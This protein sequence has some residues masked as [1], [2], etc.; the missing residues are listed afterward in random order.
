MIEKSIHRLLMHSFSYE[1]GH[2]DINQSKLLYL[3]YMV[4]DG[5]IR[6]LDMSEVNGY[7]PGDLRKAL[8]CPW[9]IKYAMNPAKERGTIRTYTGEI[10]P[11]SEENW[12]PFGK[13]RHRK[14]R[15]CWASPPDA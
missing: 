14:L 6:V 10:D 3:A 7:L 5:E 1:E 13:S 15:A 2:G 11:P 4:D 12:I 8:R 9:T